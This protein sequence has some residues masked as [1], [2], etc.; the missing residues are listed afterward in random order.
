MLF[1]EMFKLGSVE[2]DSTATFTTDL[3]GHAADG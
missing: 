2:P 1:I 3:N